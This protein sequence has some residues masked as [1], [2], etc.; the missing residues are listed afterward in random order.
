MIEYGLSPRVR[1]VVV[2]TNEGLSL[3]QNAA[4]DMLNL[5]FADPQANRDQKAAKDVAEWLPE[6]NQCWFVNR[7]VAVKRRYGLSMDAREEAAAR[8]VLESCSS[9]AM[10]IVDREA[11]VTP[12]PE[13]PPES[14]TQT[15][16][17]T[18][19]ASAETAPLSL[20]DSNDNGRISC[21]EAREHGITPVRS[22]HPAYPYMRDSNGD[23]VVC[24]ES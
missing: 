20:Y 9:F 17:P 16:T 21:A 12:T 15:V 5:T 18:P 4:S 14:D 23:G 24:E 2:E 6:M 7:V 19:E 1:G 22:D 8:S 13:T 10:V 11:T 3:P